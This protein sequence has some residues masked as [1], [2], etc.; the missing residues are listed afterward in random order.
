ML[1][2]LTVPFVWL[3]MSHNGI[4]AL[5][6]VSPLSEGIVFWRVIIVDT[7][8][9]KKKKNWILSIIITQGNNRN[10]CLSLFISKKNNFYE[11]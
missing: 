5:I 9:L 7:A 4:S 6:K 1:F 3:H 2:S 10:I 8:Q 11:E